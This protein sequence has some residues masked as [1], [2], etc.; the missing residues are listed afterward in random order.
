MKRT[1]AWTGYKVHLTETCEAERP[2]L[3]TNV[4][5]TT[6]A[7][8]DD[9]VTAKIHNALAEHDLLP[10]IHIADTGY[11][12]SELFVDSQERHQIELIGPTRSDNH[13]QA[14]EGAGFAAADFA[15]DWE[16][17]QVICPEGKASINWTPAIDKFKN[18]VI[19]IKFA[20]N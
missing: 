11:V 19:K 2:N 18:H 4:E 10:D 20:M 15:I 3:I 6:A 16:Q 7:V 17:Q 9:A 12:N 8:A 5:T 14:K 13:W 1:T